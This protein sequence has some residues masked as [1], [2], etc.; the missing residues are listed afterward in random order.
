MVKE[1]K[2][3]SKK[4]DMK[5]MMDIYMKLAVPGS[6]H[7]HL[8]EMVGSWTTRTVAWMEEGKPPMDSKGTCEQKMIL[9][10]RF[11]QQEY[12]GDMMGTTFN[13]INIIGYDNHTKKYVSVWLDS[14]GTGIYFFEGE[15]SP[16][17]KTITQESR[18]DD[19][20]RGPMTWRSVSRVAD[21]NT[22]VYEA[23]ITAEGGEEEKMMEMTLAR[24]K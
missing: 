2:Q 20:V 4:M 5:A 14:M 16:D 21:P 7:K 10:G 8:Q 18:Y 12:T 19:P 6:S 15:A 22:V 11:L 3:E 24:K 17:G 9:G 1:G 23:Y 13:G